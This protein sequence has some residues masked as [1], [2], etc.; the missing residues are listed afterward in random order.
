MASSSPRP[1]R[2]S[3]ALPLALMLSLVAF[4][5]RGLTAQ[6]RDYIAQGRTVRWDRGRSL[7]INESAAVAR[8]D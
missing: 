5:P 8:N 6:A 2:A 4:A 3:R 1:R 7:E